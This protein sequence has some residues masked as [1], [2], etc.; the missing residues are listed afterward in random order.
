[1]EERLSTENLGESKQHIPEKKNEVHKIEMFLGELLAARQDA[2]VEQKL[3]LLANACLSGWLVG[4]SGCS[5]AGYSGCSLAGEMVSW[6]GY[7]SISSTQMIVQCFHG[8]GVIWRE[9]WV[10]DKELTSIAVISP[11][12]QR[13][14]Q[15]IHFLYILILSFKHGE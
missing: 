9:Y 11:F 10:G 6:G 2:E 13:I 3:F 12:V 15:S 4:Y 7:V 8:S 14:G 5:L 1:M